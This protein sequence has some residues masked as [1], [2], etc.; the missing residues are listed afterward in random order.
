M[1]YQSTN[2]FKHFARTIIF[3]VLFV[4]IINF[5]YDPF[6]RYL[7]LIYRKVYVNEY[8]DELNKSNHGIEFIYENIRILKNAM[9][10]ENTNR[11]CIVYGSSHGLQFGIVKQHNI[12]SSRCNSLINISVSSANIQDFL[13]YSYKFLRTDN[14]P[15]I[16]FFELSP[17]IF[18]KRVSM[19]VIEIILE[20]YAYLIQ[21]ND[22]MNSLR[23]F[24]FLY[25]FFT[26]LSYLNNLISIFSYDLF[27]HSVNRAIENNFKVSSRLTYRT[28]SEEF[29]F[30]DGYDYNVLLPDGTLL[31]E[32]K[33]YE[34]IKNNSVTLG[35]GSYNIRNYKNNLRLYLLFSEIVQLLQKKNF[36]IYF[37]LTPYHP[38]VFRDSNAKNR[39]FL[40][41]TESEIREI[42]RKLNIKIFGSYNSIELGCLPTEFLDDNHP[43][44]S[45]L[46]RINEN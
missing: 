32:K 2:Y 33:K 4:S 36:K 1:N 40:N 19:E 29:N 45:C 37:I 43:T 46:D 13:V 5:L 6:E 42:G 34:R 26:E 7:E 17:W 10:A 24:S 41:Q 18:Q 22:I 35:D 3:F 39:N 12:V 44:R 31:Y 11:Q 21:D 27:Y 15:K 25:N 28:P 23:N 9:L 38:D 20:P 30:Y 16:I 14:P 8:I